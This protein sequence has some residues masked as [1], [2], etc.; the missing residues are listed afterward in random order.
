[1]LEFMQHNSRLFSEIALM[2][3]SRD[4]L[5]QLGFMPNIL[6]YELSAHLNI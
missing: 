1:M 2:S 4:F 3:I 6:K 5:T